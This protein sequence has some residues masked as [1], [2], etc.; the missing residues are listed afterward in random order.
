MSLNLTELHG[1]S[2][3]IA[4]KLRGAGLTDSDKLLDA[5]AEPDARKALASKLGIDERA[6]LE[7]GN[8]ADLRGSRASAPSIPTCWSSQAWIP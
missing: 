3:E 8:R 1:V 2:P 6:L 5:V 7:L 4:D